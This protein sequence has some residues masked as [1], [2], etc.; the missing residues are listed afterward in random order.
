MSRQAAFCIALIALAVPA[1]PLMLS[2]A[3][4]SKAAPARFI[5][6]RALR[7]PKRRW[8]AARR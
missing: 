1:L 7:T 2:V 4:I 6:A 3:R 8:R 5:Q